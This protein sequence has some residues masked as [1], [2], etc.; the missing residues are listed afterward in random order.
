MR[1]H[2]LPAIFVV[3]M[4]AVLGIASGCSSLS[5]SV[6]PKKV[7]KVYRLW[8]GDNQGAGRFCMPLASADGKRKVFVDS[9]PVATSRDFIAGRLEKT[10]DSKG[11]L[12]LQAL[13]VVR[14]RL[15]QADMELRNDP[16]LMVAVDEFLFGYVRPLEFSSE[17]GSLVLRGL[18]WEDETQLPAIAEAVSWN[19]KAYYP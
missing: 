18:R 10:G 12:V 17:S 15:E 8:Q 5:S 16:Y 2:F 13:P 11:D 9:A 4:L 3:W 1:G 7:V 6:A 14:H 19:H